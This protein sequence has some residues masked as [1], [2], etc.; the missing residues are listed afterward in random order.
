MKGIEHILL[1]GSIMI[2]LNGRLFGQPKEER[3][4][5]NAEYLVTLPKNYGEDI[6]KEWP[7]L[8]FLHGSRQNSNFKRVKEDFLPVKLKEDDDSQLILISPINPYKKWSVDLLNIILDDV[9]DKYKVDVDRIYLSG[10]SLGGWG[11]WEWAL[12]N[13][14]RFAAIA[15]ISGSMLGGIP[16][17]WK[18]RHLPIW[19]FNGARDRNTDAS[20]NIE[21]IQTLRKFNDN[22]K[23]TV[24]PDAGHDIYNWPYEKNNLIN[25]ML[26]QNKKKSLPKPYK[27]DKETY[28]SFCGAYTNRHKDTIIITYRDKQIFAKTKNAELVLIPESKNLFYVK[29]ASWI[30]VAFNQRNCSVSALNILANHIIK[31]TKME[32]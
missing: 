31:F 9:I 28:D 7:V 29:S 20:Y 12:K 21:A 13:P 27:L 23:I 26:K 17:P 8:I 3:I 2:G 6:L 22:A 14:E 18:L 19:A 24:Y 15:P 11:T 30:G 10:H 5:L 4:T 16:N 32:K 25:W 1:A